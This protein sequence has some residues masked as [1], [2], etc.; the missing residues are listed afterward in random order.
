MKTTIIA[1]LLSM[2]AAL[3]PNLAQAQST[4][5]ELMTEFYEIADA[6]PMDTEKLASFIA[7]NY[8]DYDSPQGG[9][10]V[11]T[12]EQMAQFF[13]SLA[14]GSPDSKHKIEFIEPVGDNKALVRWRYIGTHTGT[15]FGIPATGNKIDIAGMELWEFKDGKI[16]GLWHVE[17]LMTMFQQLSPKK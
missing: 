13:A 1:S 8:V 3:L 12:G 7:D 6:R 10:R 17:Q 14:T 2:V 15:L 16:V 9:E 11:A 4:P 5:V